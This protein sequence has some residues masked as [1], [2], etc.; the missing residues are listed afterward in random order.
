MGLAPPGVDVISAPLDVPDAQINKHALS[1]QITTHMCLA[2]LDG[3]IAVLPKVL[4]GLYPSTTPHR[5]PL[6][7]SLK[8][9]ARHR[10]S[11]LARAVTLGPAVQHAA[12]RAAQAREVGV[13]GGR[14]L[15]QARGG[16]VQLQARGRGDGTLT[17]VP[18]GAG[19]HGDDPGVQ[20]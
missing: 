9:K 14:I 19:V 2:R 7:E 4:P 16:G 15:I 12:A 13:C 6:E 18:T 10:E 11:G 8:M 5:T 3:V 1:T 17:V 20:Q